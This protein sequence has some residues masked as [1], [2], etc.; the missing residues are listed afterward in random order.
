MNDMDGLELVDAGRYAEKGYP[1]EI[2]E[3]L[4]R[5]APVRYFDPPGYRPF[6][7]ITKHADVAEISKQ[8]DKFLSQPRLTIVR[9]ELERNRSGS[10]MRIRTLVNM[11]P[12]EHRDYRKL[13]SPWFT[14]NNLRILEERM[15]QSA[16][17]LVDGMMESGGGDFVTDVAA[18]H[19]LRLIAHLFGVAEEDE[20]FVLKATNEIFGSEDPEFQRTADR[21]QD[22]MALFGELFQFFSG[23]ST[24]RKAKPRDDLA[25]ILANA[26]LGG[27][28]IGGGELFGYYLIVLTAGHETTRNALSGG[29]LALIEHPD[30]MRRL[31]E[32]PGLIATAA[33][34]IIRWTT[35]VNHFV[36]T[37]S[38]DYEL[39]GQKIRQ[40]DSLALFY[41]SANRDEEVFDAP[42]E[43]RVDRDP[44]PHLAFGIGEHFCL[45]ANL[46]RMEIRVLLT[47]LLP[48]LDSVE[49]AGPPERL[50]SSFVGGVKHLPLRYSIRPRTG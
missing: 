23:I 12:P 22:G 1:H 34:E 35:P 19:P 4:R 2:W 13:A 46:A 26:K 10:G 41:A 33:D 47:E 39:R 50:A 48:R 15:E 8:P 25:S 11:D 30:A 40:G 38:C 37:A 49:L 43:F 5:E 45:G 31:K 3:R 7:A 24:D 29:M 27:E 32:E 14:P 9:E 20:P 17:E 6:W 21:R 28:D 16:R 36:R 42:F 44:N 18:Q